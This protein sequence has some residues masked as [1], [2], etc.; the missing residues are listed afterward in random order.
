MTA[1][2]EREEVGQAGALLMGVMGCAG[3][4][5]TAGMD[6]GVF[7]VVHDA[8]IL[9]ASV[10]LV[11]VVLVPALYVAASMSGLVIRLPELGAAVLAG[12]RA[13]GVAALGLIAPVL[14]L[15][16]STSNATVSRLL[17]SAVLLF[18]GVLGLSAIYS[19]LF[20]EAEAPP[21]VPCLYLCW[22]LIF[23]GIAAKVVLQSLEI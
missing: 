13:T 3:L 16:A 18:V 14:F 6:S 17:V 12:L 8:A 1:I 19:R 4:G 15:M 7:A 20:R 21:G 9:P 23:L 10:A 11:T 2:E 22:S 5:A